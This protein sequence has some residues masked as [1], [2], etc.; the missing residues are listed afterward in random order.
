VSTDP[1]PAVTAAGY[2]R[3]AEHGVSLDGVY[4]WD[5]HDP[6]RALLALVGIGH[7]LLALAEKPSEPEAAPAPVRRRVRWIW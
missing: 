2:L 6:R 3:A 1:D 5:S 7:A 4:Y